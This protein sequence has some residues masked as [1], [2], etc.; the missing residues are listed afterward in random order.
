MSVCN[1]MIPIQNIYFMLCYAWGYLSKTE[2]TSVGHEKNVDILNLF[3]TALTRGF[4]LLR[5][6][7]LYRG[8]VEVGEET[9]RIR[10]KIGFQESLQK[11]LHEQGKMYCSFDELSNNVLPNQILKSTFLLLYRYNDLDKDL[12]EEITECIHT[13]QFVDAI[14]LSPR[15]YGNVNLPRSFR[16]YQFLLRISQFIVENQLVNQEEGIAT[17]AAFNDEKKMCDL[18]E[19][20]LRSFYQWE[21][22]KNDSSVRVL[23]K[24]IKWLFDSNSSHLPTMETDLLFQYQG[25]HFIID[26]KYYKEMFQSGWSG[27]SKSIRS[28]HL[29][30]VFA[31][32]KNW[33]HH[34][35]LQKEQHFP[36][37]GMLIYPVT[38]GRDTFQETYTFEN[39]FLTVA[40]INFNQPSLG[41]KHDLLALVEE[42]PDVI[43]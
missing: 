13:L 31:Y 40:S 16:L 1:S 20:F 5:K 36:I 43:A 17:F 30:Q 18:F 3:A 35:Q 11:L 42:K 29:Y 33:E 39:H 23:K 27:T 4:L 9:R 8:Y 21:L 15:V 6:R 10:G 26:A 32:I 25:K 28:G 2:L 41:I 7:G 37:H 38:E 19:E 12:R 14:P 22:R 34:L 24:T